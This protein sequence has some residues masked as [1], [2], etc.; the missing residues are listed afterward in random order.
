METLLCALAKYLDVIN[1]QFPGLLIFFLYR[2]YFH[3]PYSQFEVQC[4]ILAFHIFDEGGKEASM[5][6][7]FDLKFV[8]HP[9]FK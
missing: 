9:R 6:S 4:K 5:G 3:V 7:S 1:Y 8:L 2:L